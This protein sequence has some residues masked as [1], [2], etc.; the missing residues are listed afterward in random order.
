MSPSYDPSPELAHTMRRWEFHFVIAGLVLLAASIVGGF[1]G[2]GDFFH[3]W[4]I[5][6]LFWLGLVLGS[7]GFL[8]MQYL[9][10]GAW[11]IVTQRVFE[12][13]SRTLPI[14]ALFF[15]PLAFGMPQLYDW[16]NPERVRSNQLLQHRAGYMNPAMFL[17]RTVVYFAVWITFSYFLNRWSAE[18]DEAAAGQ[19][20]RLARLS[21]A[22]LIVYVFTITFAAVDWAASLETNFYSTIWGFLFVASQGLIAIAF[23]IFALWL[24]GKAEP[25]SQVLRPSHFHDLGKLMLMMLMLWAYFSFSQLLIIWSGD[26]PHEISYYLP[27]F[28]TSWG[29][30][31]AAL[32][33]VQFLIPF[34]LLLNEPLKRNA[35]LLSG[36]VVIVLVMQYMDVVW[37]ILPGYHKEGFHMSWLAVV[38]PLAMGAFW[39]SAFLRQLARRPLIPVNAPD[40]EE[41]LIHE[42]D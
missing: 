20:H 13:A 2:P 36:V 19:R 14:I 24:L 32:I 3:A 30:L 31:G 40:L 21:A 38:A 37:F 16:A 28:A 35:A 9:T 39:V 10:R 11:G 41:A 29:W 26:L 42:T 34:L 17:I 23:S 8:M 18:E 33:V 6:F 1:F 15:V 4:L 12:A 7:M 5:G 25:M 22:G 27:R